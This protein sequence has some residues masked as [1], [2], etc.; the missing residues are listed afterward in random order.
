MAVPISNPFG[1]AIVVQK[2]LAYVLAQDHLHIIEVADPFHPI[3]RASVGDVSNMSGMRV[4]DG[5]AYI[6]H[7]GNMGILDISVP[8]APHWLG[9]YVPPSPTI[10]D[11]DVSGS[12]AYLT[13]DTGGLDVVDVSNPMSP[14]EVGSAKP[15]DR[16][17][18][19]RVVN[20]IAYVGA[21][22]SGVWVYR[23]PAS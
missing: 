15:A 17:L 11:I 23:A 10:T 4:V 18:S 20:G 7:L 12:R 13:L 9:T 6:N 2:N 14:H 3:Q 8:T 5:R 19:V 16:S 1:A 21:W 22:N